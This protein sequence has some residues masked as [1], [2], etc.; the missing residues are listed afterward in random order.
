MTSASNLSTAPFEDTEL[1]FAAVPFAA[2]I[3]CLMLSGEIYWRRRRQKKTDAKQQPQV[4]DTKVS[5]LVLEGIQS[6][7]DCNF[8]ID[9]TQELGR[10]GMGTVYYLLRRLAWSPR[11]S[12]DCE[13]AN[14]NQ[15][16]GADAGIAPSQHLLV[17]RS[18]ACE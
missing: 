15:R 3:L 13:E 5:A 17:L 11:C 8:T 14:A 10:G 16:S 6:I 2:V 9:W 7:G 4:A 12:Q 18:G 1:D